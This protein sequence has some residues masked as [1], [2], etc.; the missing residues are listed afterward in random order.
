MANYRDTFGHDGHGESLMPDAAE[1]FALA[2]RKARYGHRIW[3][4]WQDRA[5]QYHAALATSESIKA[6]LLAVGTGGHFSG[7]SGDRF[8]HRLNWRT[9][10]AWLSNARAGYLQ[11]RDA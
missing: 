4:V 2:R 3:I 1:A 7:F 11:R 10:L 8:G 9:G 5:N 6:A